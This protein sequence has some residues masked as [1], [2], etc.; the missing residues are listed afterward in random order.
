[1]DPKHAQYIQ[2]AEHCQAEALKMQADDMREA[3]LRLAQGWLDMLPR[4]TTPVVVEFDRMA[5]SM[6]TGQEDSTSSH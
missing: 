6:G 4:K 5:D 3:W 2:Q 1:M